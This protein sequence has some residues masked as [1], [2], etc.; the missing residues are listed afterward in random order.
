VVFALFMF[1]YVVTVKEVITLLHLL[2]R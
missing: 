2:H 1:A